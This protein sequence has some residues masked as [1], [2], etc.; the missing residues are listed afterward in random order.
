[1][2][3]TFMLLLYC[4]NTLQHDY[5]DNTAPHISAPTKTEHTSTTTELPSSDI[6]SI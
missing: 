3:S 1:M 5:T 4:N 6:I 2:K